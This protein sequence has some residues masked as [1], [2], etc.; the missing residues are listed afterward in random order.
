MLGKIALFITTFIISFAA[1]NAAPA[2]ST[3]SVFSLI[4]DFLI[5]DAEIEENDSLAIDTT[6]NVDD[7]KFPSRLFGDMVYNKW[8]LSID[9][10]S[11]KTMPQ[12]SRFEW[13]E[14]QRRLQSRL[15]QLKQNTYLANPDLVPYNENLLPDPPKEYHAKVDPRKATIVIEEDPLA[16]TQVKDAPKPVEIKR[17]NWLHDFQASR[18]FSQAYNSPNWYQGGNNNLNII[19]QGLHSVKLNQA[20]HP[21]IMFENI[22]QYKLALNSAPEDSLRNYSI[23]EDLF[24]INTKFGLRAAKNWYY[25]ITSMFKTQML[26]NYKS[27]TNDIK[28]AFLSPGELNIG[29]GMSYSSTNKNK[30]FTF[31]TSISPLSY[32]LKI[33]TDDRLNKEDFGIKQNRNTAS[34]YGSNAEAKIKWKAAYNITYSSRMYFFTDYSYVQGDWEHTISFDVN[35][36]LATQIYVHLRYDSST[37]RLPDTK[38]HTW[39]L[40]EIL[41]FG[42]TY[43]FST[44]S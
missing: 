31:D 21:N 6:L 11:L 32:N 22:I 5:T 26:N 2:E 42:L 23:S 17:K 7:M 40:K 12:T 30:T 10:I 43:K 18:H 4:E 35:R 27:N 3:D 8:K 29:L 41:S 44:A 38:W 28:A 1:A 15:T 37:S 20:F 16:V 39:Q 14:R 13:V 36:Y 19:C 9:T 25:S 33:C 34:Q 24:Q